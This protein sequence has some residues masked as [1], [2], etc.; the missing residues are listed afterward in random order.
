MTG[1]LESDMRPCHRA[2]GGLSP[3]LH[4]KGTFDMV[5]DGVRL[6]LVAHNGLNQRRRLQYARPK[7]SL[8]LYGCRIPLYHSSSSFRFLARMAR[9]CSSSWCTLLR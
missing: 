5:L 7:I 3:R 2:S 4:K 9:S 8:S 6:E 1:T